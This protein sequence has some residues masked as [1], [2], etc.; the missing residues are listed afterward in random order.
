MI[1]LE[2]ALRLAEQLSAIETRTTNDF[3]RVRLAK[4]TMTQLVDRVRELQRQDVVLRE[5]IDRL[6]GDC[7]LT[8]DALQRSLEIM[9]AAIKAR[10]ENNER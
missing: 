9:A 3:E 7:E 4:R 10:K 2:D 6:V 1:N 8:S 5:R